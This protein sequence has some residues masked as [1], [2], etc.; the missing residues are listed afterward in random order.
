[1]KSLKRRILTAVLA[2]LLLNWG[3]WLGW[4]TFEMGR[5]ET[6][7]WDARLRDVASQAVLSMP[8]DIM[9]RSEPTGFRLPE[10]V[11]TSELRM[12]FQIWSMASRRQIVHSVNAPPGPLN[13]AFADGYADVELDGEPW[14]VYSVTDAEGRI[15]AQ[16]GHSLAARRGDILQWLGASLK[17]SALLF[18]FLALSILLAIDRA[19]RR[20]DRV[21]R[22]VQQR[23]PLDLAPLPDGDVPAELRPLI[24]AINRQ[25]GRVHTALARERRLIADAAHELR[26][27]LAALKMQAEVAL[28]ARH[29]DERHSALC[30]L[31]DAARRA[32]RLSEQLLDQARLD[33][34]EATVPGGEVDLATLTAMIIADHQARAQARHQRIQ[35]D[36]RPAFVSG[37][38]DSLGILVSNLVDNALRYTPEGGRVVVYCGPLENSAVGLRVLDNGPGVPA[39]R[40]ERIFERFYRQ[41]GQAQRGGGIGLSLV[42]QIARLHRARIDCGAGLDGRGFGIAV[43]FAPRR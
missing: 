41:P 23:D 4:Q 38:L 11:Q 33:A 22:A 28:G 40:H 32:A 39:D 35:L 24:T 9:E 12:S 1:M 36:A 16:A 13:P 17:A 29:A 21:G 20:L 2:A 43:G 6:G 19:M 30:K 37:D 10:P 15:Q 14:R 25:F 34:M 31:L 8:L 42:A 27:P 5:R 3:V 7:T 18:L 26:T